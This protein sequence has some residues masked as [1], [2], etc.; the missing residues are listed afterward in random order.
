MNICATVFVAPNVEGRVSGASDTYS[1]APCC[2]PL[3]SRLERMERAI[4]LVCGEQVMLTLRIEH[5]SGDAK[6]PPSVHINASTRL[7]LPSGARDCGVQRRDRWIAQT[8]STAACRNANLMRWRDPFAFSLCRRSLGRAIVSIQHEFA[9][10]I[11]IPNSLR[12]YA[13]FPKYRCP[14]FR[15]GFVACQHI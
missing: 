7:A 14:G 4:S 1:A 2:R 6:D 12:D 3:G 8:A 5:R 9:E 13:K 10:E 15:R 11:A